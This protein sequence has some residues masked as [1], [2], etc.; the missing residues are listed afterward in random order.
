MTS[1]KVLDQKKNELM[2]REELHALLEH[3][4]MP[5]PV[6]EEILPHLESVLKVD[7]DR[8]LIHKIFTQT[9]RGESLLK[10]YVYDRKE[11]MPKKALEILQKRAAK[12]GKK[13][14]EEPAEAPKEHKA[15]HKQEAPK[16][17]HKEAKHEEH[18]PEHKHEEHKTEHKEHDHKKEEKK[19]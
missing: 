6:R 15:E 13:S 14:K 8:I 18:K 10:V 19:E 4:G 17:E 11:D 3:H 7:G 5:T 1:L 9:G 2:G 12:R 16:T